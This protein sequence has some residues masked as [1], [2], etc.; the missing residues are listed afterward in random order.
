M[1]GDGAEKPFEATPQKLQRAREKGEIAR[2]QELST[3]LSYAGMLAAMLGLGGVA[4]AWLRDAGGALLERAHA[5]APLALADGTPLLAIAWAG[6]AALALLLA[7]AA[8]L[9]LAG[10]VAARAVVWAPSRIAPKLNRISPLAGAKNKFGPSGLFE[11]AKSAVKMAVL[12]TVLAWL[13]WS[14]RD[15][16]L[17]S[18]ALSPEAALLLM[19][20][21][22]ALFGAAVLAISVLIAAADLAW[23]HHRHRVQNRMTREEMVDESKQSE[24]DP[25]M[26][27]QRRRRAEEIATN[28][29]I[30][31]VEEATVVVTNPTHFAVA[32][33]WSPDDPTPP[34]CVAKGVDEVAARIREAARRHGVPLYPDPPTARALHATMDLGEPIPREHFAAVATVIRFVL[35]THGGGAGGGGGPGPSGEGA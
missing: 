12:G 35:E 16:I 22:L 13:L 33:R 9:I 5:L 8:A 17:A 26:K 24:G 2:S 6:L 34:V 20:E 10:L 25:H 27:G 15:E 31:D 29:M 14:R 32:L 1:S 3:A 28:R 11:F 4:A 23:Q 30:R 21:F 19:V 18:A 7:P